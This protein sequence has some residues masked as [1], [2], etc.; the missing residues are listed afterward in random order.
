MR[1]VVA[2]AAG[3]LATL[4]A[5]SGKDKPAAAPVGRLV[6]G[7][8]RH[9]RARRTHRATATNCWSACATAAPKSSRRSSCSTETSARRSRSS[10]TQRAR[11]PSKRSGT[12]S[13]TTASSC[14]PSEERPVVRTRTCAGRYGPVRSRPAWSSIHRSS[15]RSAGRVRVLSTARSSHRAAA[16]RCSVRGAAYET[17]NDGAVWLP[18]G[19]AKWIR[20]DPAKTALQSTPSLL[21]GPSFGTT[22]GDCDRAGRIAVSGWHRTWSRRRRPSGDPPSST[23]AGAGCALPEPGDRSQAVTASCAKD[24]VISGY[25]DGKLAIWQLDAARYGEA[26]GRRA[27]DPGRRQGQAAAADRRRRQDRP[28]HCPGQQGEGAQRA[29]RQLDRA[30]V[31]RRSRQVR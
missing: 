20:Q 8:R 12:R 3:S 7:R 4:A 15:T 11:T 26:A 23:R 19:D 21:V 28:D 13:R 17:G 9:G 16:A 1:R 31:Q 29:G 10:P 6:E 22:L 30:R 2:V 5:C 18:Q 27:V 24:C 14:W 25:V